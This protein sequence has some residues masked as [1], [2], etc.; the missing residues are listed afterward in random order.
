M[1]TIEGHKSKSLSPRRM[2][3]MP[4]R[5]PALATDPLGDWW[6][7]WPGHVFGSCKKCALLQYMMKL[8][9]VV[10]KVHIWQIITAVAV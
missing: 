9:R 10:S 1:F 4:F 6:R 2:E 5:I 7:A 8:S 3:P